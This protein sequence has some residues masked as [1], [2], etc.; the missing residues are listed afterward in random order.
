MSFAAQLRTTRLARSRFISFSSFQ[1]SR[2]KKFSDHRGA[3]NEAL[4]RALGK[5]TTHET[6][7]D[8]V[9]KKEKFTLDDFFSNMDA[10]KSKTRRSNREG[11]R[12]RK[13]PGKARTHTTENY[14]STN[15]DLSS[16]FDEVNSI[17]KKNKMK[18]GKQ[19]SSVHD[20]KN[21]S[22]LSSDG[23]ESSK[24][25]IFDAIPPSKP[26]SS[27][28]YDEETFDQYTEMLE[29]IISMP[30]FLR[31]HTKSPIDD[32]RAKSIIE[33]LKAEEPVIDCN[34]PSLDRVMNEGLSRE[35]ES[36]VGEA[37][38]KELELQRQEIKDHYGWDEQQ[39]TLA[40]KALTNL[41]GLCAKKASGAPLDIGWRKL[42]EAGFKMDKDMLHNYLYVSS[43][44]SNR[45]IQISSSGGSLIDFLKSN[46]N[47]DIANMQERPEEENQSQE[48]IN[49]AS[50]VANVQDLLFKPTEQSTSIRV[51]TLVSL[52]R[53]KEAERVLDTIAVSFDVSSP[54]AMQN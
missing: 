11:S 49:T 1:R 4:F 32:E 26:R 30:K 40:V 53:A 5:A 10:S 13:G 19:E 51:R 29:R 45:S 43:T 6:T 21:E 24:F 12:S 41:G 33:W 16:F 50:E 20:A 27:N 37:F 34:L 35:E 44:F 48:K 2:C 9:K 28:A 17:M 7:S 31:K 3:E 46:G 22:L 52:K 36:G 47:S 23:K 39:Y 8:E 15:E 14:A 42:K 18:L 25:S 38:R 54:L